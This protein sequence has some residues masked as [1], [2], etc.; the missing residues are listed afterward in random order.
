MRAIAWVVRVLL[1][2]TFG[3]SAS[4]KLDAS[5]N[6]AE[7]FARW[8]YPVPLM[9]AIGTAELLASIAL[10][11]PRFVSAGCV[12]LGLVLL[13]SIGTHFQQFDELG[14]PLLP[15][16]LLA[17]VATVWYLENRARSAAADTARE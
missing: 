3:I 11:V 15:S 8:G 12:V 6:I 10:L 9:M 17:L 7:A 1:A 4:G 13:G 2:L 5:G 14:W 16:A